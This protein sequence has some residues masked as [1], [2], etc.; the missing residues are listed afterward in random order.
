MRL[1]AP[2][3]FVVAGLLLAGAARAQQSATGMDQIGPAVRPDS[4][5]RSVVQITVETAPAAPTAPQVSGREGGSRSTAQLTSERGG[6]RASP[7]LNRETR[8]T[9]GVE[10]LSSP[11]QGRTAAVTR[12]YGSDRCD[13]RPA[14]AT[15]EDACARVIETRAAE[16]ERPAAPTDSRSPEERLLARDPVGS[17]TDARLAAR[18]FADGKVEESVAAQAVASGELARRNT[19]EDRPPDGEVAGEQSVAAAL[20]Q[21][22]VNGATAA[23][24][25][26]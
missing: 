14:P 5:Q 4:A 3:L 8:S 26:N 18:R 10:A 13:A 15:E 19:D 21:A 9:A 22:I 25:R 24:P 12:V 17:S 1:L 2:G 7:Q 6:S 16:F 23:A 11:A 20:I